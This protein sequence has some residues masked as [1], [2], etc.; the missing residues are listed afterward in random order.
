MGGV[1]GVEGEEAEEVEL[2][3]SRLRLRDD[4]KSYSGFDMGLI[5]AS[6]LTPQ[7]Y[8]SSVGRLFYFCIE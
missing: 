4:Q 5:E 6:A 1:Q 8:L 2:A 3:G 7:S